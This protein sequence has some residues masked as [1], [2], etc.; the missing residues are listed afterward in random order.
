MKF[1]VW[2]LENSYELTSV[3]SRNW[4][5][6]LQ[7]RKAL[8]LLR[9]EALDSEEAG[10]VYERFVFG[11]NPD[12]FIPLNE[13]ASNFLLPIYP[14][15]FVAGDQV[16]FR[17][18]YHLRIDEHRHVEYPKGLNAEVLNGDLDMPENVWLRFLR[19][20]EPVETFLAIHQDDACEILGYRDRKNDVEQGGNLI[21]RTWLKDRSTINGG[22]PWISNSSHE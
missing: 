8:L 22:A 20:A 14:C 1:E 16:A 2:Q 17:K 18:K 13:P 6:I 3:P 19:Q 10:Q 7:D 5:S 15:G 9:F 11:G 21:N 12:R 4:W